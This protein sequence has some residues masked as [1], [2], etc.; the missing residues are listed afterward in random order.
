MKRYCGREFTKTELEKIRSLINDNPEFHRARLSREVCQI[1]QWFKPDGGLKEM[2]CRVAMLRMHEDGLINLPQPRVK[3]PALRKIEFTSATEPQRLI[4]HPVNKLPALEIQIVN[5]TNSHLWNEYIER[6]HYLGYTPLPG[7]QLRYF[8]SVNDQILAL[9]GFGAAAW[10]TA[11]RDKYIGWDQEQRKRNLYM[12][13]NNARFLI[14]PWIKSK[15]LASKVLAMLARQLPDDWNRKYGI[16][17]VLL[18]TFV[19]EGR[20]SGT[21]YRAANWQMVGK[22]KGRGKL[23]P[24]GVQSVPIKDIWLYPLKK[25]FR[26]ILKNEE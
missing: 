16:R 11:P 9:A 4:V 25:N 26:S 1:L 18:E 20:F 5:R 23:G 17:P 15:N 10:Q 8:I 14:L 24:M 2:S 6:Y 13:A 19:E 3:K 21:C 7:A 12:I 22:T